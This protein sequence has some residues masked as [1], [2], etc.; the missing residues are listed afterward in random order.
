MTNLEQ[1]S[2]A[3]D[4]IIATSPA[5]TRTAIIDKDGLTLKEVQQYLPSNYGAFR[6]PDGRIQ[7]TGRDSHGWTLDGY[8][9]PRLASGLIPAKEHIEE[10]EDRRKFKIGDRVRHVDQDITGDIIRYD[11]VKYAV[12]D[13]EPDPE[14][15]PG[16]GEVPNEDRS[17]LS[18][19]DSE[20]V[21]LDD[22]WARKYGVK[23]HIESE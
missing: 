12:L 15:E 8:V 4:K 5:P 1:F 7:V 6:R 11:G 13:D 10:K 16:E 20:L 9:L 14:C 2:C 18:Y 3:L 22:N 17:T 23:P 19:R 21:L